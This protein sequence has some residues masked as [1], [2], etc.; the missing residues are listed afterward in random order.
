MNNN[1]ILYWGVLE[2]IVN[3]L[4]ATLVF[5]T[6]IHLLLFRFKT[7]QLYS[8]TMF[9]TVG[10][11]LLWFF[12]CPFGK[13]VQ[14]LAWQT[15]RWYKYEYGDSLVKCFLYYIIYDTKYSFILATIGFLTCFLKSLYG[16]ATGPRSRYNWIAVV[17]MI[18]VLIASAILI[19]SPSAQEYRDAMKIHQEQQI[20]TNSKID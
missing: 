7:R 14:T 13:Y 19:E 3:T 12:F 2:Q 6:L 11:L 5:P 10:S 4:C 17:S 9:L 20:I 8:L 15:E 1:Y 16:I 18:S